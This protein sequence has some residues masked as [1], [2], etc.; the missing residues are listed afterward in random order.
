MSTTAQSVIITAYKLQSSPGR[1]P[2]STT[3]IPIS[4]WG[5]EPRIMTPQQDVQSDVDTVHRNTH[6]LKHDLGDNE[7]KLSDFNDVIKRLYG[8]VRDCVHTIQRTH[9]KV[10]SQKMLAANGSEGDENMESPLEKFKQDVEICTL[11]VESSFK[12][13]RE[14]Q[15]NVAKASGDLS[16]ALEVLNSIVAKFPSENIAGG[17]LAGSSNEPV[18]QTGIPWLG[19]LG[20]KIMEEF[21]LSIQQAELNGDTFKTVTI[22]ELIRSNPGV[23]P[24]TAEGLA[25]LGRHIEAEIVRRAGDTHKQ[26]P[27][28]KKAPKPSAKR[29]RAP[30]NSKKGEE[31]QSRKSTAREVKKAKISLEPAAVPGGEP[32]ILP[33]EPLIFPGES[34]VLPVELPILPQESPILPKESPI[35]PGESLVLPEESLILP[36]ESLI[37]PG[38]SPIFP[39]ESPNSPKELPSSPEEPQILPNDDPETQRFVQQLWYLNDTV[40]WTEG[41]GANDYYGHYEGY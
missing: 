35:L 20:Q 14:S 29:P 21:K 6:N 31:V 7:G 5:N 32:Q 33:N 34:P 18:G 4:H 24:P 39:Q 10:Q 16:W 19:M 8:G 37:L 2:H 25:G 36:E 1:R 28:N 11:L 26:D 3:T 13:L 23:N 9:E 40:P 38:E 30:R 41:P 15:K 22:D 12:E 17:N 27:T